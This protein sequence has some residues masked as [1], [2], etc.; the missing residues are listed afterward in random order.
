MLSKN[1]AEAI[2]TAQWLASFEMQ[3]YRHIN[4]EQPPAIKAIYED[5]EATQARPQGPVVYEVAKTSRS[6]PKHARYRE[7]SEIVQTEAVNAITGKKPVKEALAEMER[8][9]KG[10]GSPYDPGIG[11]KP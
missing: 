4:G 6:R 2:E 1:R 8:R 5:Q 9:L 3:K 11:R 10:L 7:F